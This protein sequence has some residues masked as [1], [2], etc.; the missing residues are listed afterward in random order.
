MQNELIV[1]LYFYRDESDF[2]FILNRET[3]KFTALL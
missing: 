2:E 3:G 1:F